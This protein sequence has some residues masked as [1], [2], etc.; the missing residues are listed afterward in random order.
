MSRIWVAL[1]GPLMN[2]VFAFAIA[3]IIWWVG[4]PVPVS[5]PI[6]G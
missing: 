6:I 5:P 1:A 2:L 3:S 4:L